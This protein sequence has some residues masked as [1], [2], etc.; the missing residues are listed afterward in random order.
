MKGFGGG[1][2]VC[3]GGLWGIDIWRVGSAICCSSLGLAVQGYI[4]L[5]ARYKIRV[6]RIYFWSM[7]LRAFFGRIFEDFFHLF[8][9]SNVNKTKTEK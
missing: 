8:F 9:V 7:G 1:S 6:S 2:A 5:K 3:D 4:T